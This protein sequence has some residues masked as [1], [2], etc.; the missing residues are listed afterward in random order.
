MTHLNENVTPIGIPDQVLTL[1]ENRLFEMKYWFS[2][3]NRSDITMPPIENPT[4]KHDQIKDEYVGQVK[5]LGQRIIELE[6]F[7]LLTKQ[8][9]RKIK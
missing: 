5:L 4:E 7:I 1:C 3:L 2:V 6:K 9:N 8:N